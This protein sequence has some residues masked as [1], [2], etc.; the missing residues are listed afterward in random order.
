MV[1]TII[2][3]I[4]GRNKVLDFRDGLVPANVEDYA[5]LHGAGGKDYAASSVIKIYLCDYSAGTGKDKSKTVSASISPELCEQIFEVC[6]RNI[7]NQ[8][9]PNNFD[10]FT[11]QRTANKRLT[12]LGDMCFGVLNNVTKVLGRYV[13]TSEAGEA[14]SAGKVAKGLFTLLNK[15]KE[16]A[17]AGPKAMTYPAAMFLPQHMDFSHAQARVHNYKSKTGGGDS[18]PV[19][20][21][22]IWHVTYRKQGDLG[23]YPWTIKVI[24]GKAKIQV[25]PNGATTFVASTMTDVEEAFIQVSD[26]DM[27]RAMSRVIHFVSVWENLVASKVVAQGRA[28]REEERKEYL[29]NRNAGETVEETQANA[30]PEAPVEEGPAA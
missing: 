13:E 11:E 9:I 29:E 17:E 20:Q 8:V 4:N 15:T 12:L 23:N 2:A 16:R 24:N 6:K 18:A 27:F 25:Q 14:P 26:A 1:S 5:M 30:A 10:F 21:L 28:K 19:Q 7:G 22:Q 3:K